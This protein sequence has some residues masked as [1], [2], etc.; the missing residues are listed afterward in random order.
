MRQNR[1]APFPGACVLAL[2]LGTSA[3]A[4]PPKS[5]APPEPV[6]P[7]WLGESD[8]AGGATLPSVQ[9]IGWSADE[10]RYV[11]RTF[12]SR[13]EEDLSLAPEEDIQA[14]KEA[15][16]Y[17]ADRQDKD[18]FCKGYVDHQGKRFKGALSLMVFERDKLLSFFPIQDEPKC[19]SPKAAAARLAEAKTKLAGLGI[20]LARPGKDVALVSRKRVP[21]TPEKQPAY[22]LEYLDK[23]KDVEDGPM[24]SILR[25][26]LEL[27]AYREGKKETVFSRKVNKNYGREMGG[28]AKDG[29]SSVHVSPS[30]EHLV[31]LGYLFSDGRGGPFY[32]LRVAT[33]LGPPQAALAPGK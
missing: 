22:E 20:D 13:G 4:Q 31:V 30:G 27:N 26:V 18:G 24:D 5:S 11:L 25:G 33:V 8:I 2:L 10:Q 28:R 9:L 3:L 16:E 29:L 32:R 23:V 21:I 6:R 17:N 1:S 14:A 7:A 12:S 19:T 15:E